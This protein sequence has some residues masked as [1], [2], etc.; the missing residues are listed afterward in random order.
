MGDRRADKRPMVAG[1]QDAELRREKALRE[2]A[3]SAMGGRQGSRD[4]RETRDAHGSAAA[5]GGREGDWG[6]PPPWWI[7]L[8]ER[9]CLK[10]EGCRRR[11]L[12]RKSMPLPNYG[13]GHGDPLAKKPRASSEPLAVALPATPKGS[14]D[15]SIPV[16]E[17]PDVECFK[18]GR[19]G[20]YQPKCKFEPLCVLCKEEGHVSAAC[21]TRGKALNL[22]I[23]G[24]AIPGEGF[25]CLQY[26]EDEEMDDGADLKIDNA[27]IISADPGQ[28]SL[29]AL[30]QELKHMVAGDWDWQVGQ[31]GDNDFSVI[32]PSADLLHMA[33]SSGKLFLSI[34]DITA[35]VR[36]S[37]H[38][39][40]APLVMPETWVQLHGIPRKHRRV[41]R[42]MEG[43]KMLGRPIVVDELSLIRLC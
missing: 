14:A 29:R 7:Q 15:A 31:V 26:D 40:V 24:S 8:Q 18:C 3:K 43:L 28:L 39:E 1:E 4:G 20:H 25:F 11:E 9:K 22:Q 37:L 10:K 23:M 27:A 32:F 33:K 38:E 5:Q 6:P 2:K 34:N 13:A 16:E 21:P 35:R 36:E 19:L 17:I 12:E 42:L 30:K 41:E